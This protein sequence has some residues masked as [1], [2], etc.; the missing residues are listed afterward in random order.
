MPILS[1][2]QTLDGLSIAAFPFS[3]NRRMAKFEQGQSSEYLSVPSP[4]KH[5]DT[6]F[7]YIDHCLDLPEEPN[8]MREYIVTA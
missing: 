6:T 3:E 2:G 7:L 4:V 8:C 1:S 5:S